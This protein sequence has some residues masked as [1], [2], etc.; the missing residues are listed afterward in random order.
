LHIAGRSLDMRLAEH[1]LRQHGIIV[2]M[3]PARKELCSNWVQ[4]GFNF[5]ARL[6]QLGFQGFPA[7]QAA[8]QWL[9][10]NSHACF[11]VLLGENPLPRTSLEGRLQRQLVLYEQGLN[12]RDPMD[13]FEEITRH[14]LLRGLLPLDH[15]YAPEELDAIA[16]AQVAF[17]ASRHPNRILCVGDSDEGQITLPI[18]ELKAKY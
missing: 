18:S 13:F 17:L 6:E 8:Y 5:Y 1:K 7:E 3:T 12:I 10:I 14:K 16:A 4:T 9:E 15:I 11:C 2:P